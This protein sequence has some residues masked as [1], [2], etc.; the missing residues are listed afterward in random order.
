MAKWTFLGRWKRFLSPALCDAYEVPCPLPPAFLRALWSTWGVG[1]QVSHSLRAPARCTAATQRQSK[2]RGDAIAGSELLCEA[3]G[4]HWGGPGGCREPKGPNAAASHA[5]VHPA[6][7][8]LAPAVPPPL[9]RPGSC[10]PPPPSTTSRAVCRVPLVLN[11]KLLGALGRSL[12]VLYSVLIGPKDRSPPHPHPGSLDVSM[13]GNCTAQ[14]LSAN[15]EEVPSPAAHP[16]P[17]VLKRQRQRWCRCLLVRFTARPR[18]RCQC[19]L[20]GAGQTF[21]ARRQ[22]RICRL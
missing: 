18:S 8:P 1:T 13:L 6:G 2:G 16:W 5:P 22:A 3:L 10:V 17:G 21:G 11:L 9:D 15:P 7:S 14:L 4:S 12:A 19:I 20:A